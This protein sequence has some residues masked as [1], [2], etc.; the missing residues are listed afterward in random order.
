MSSVTD[1]IRSVRLSVRPSVTFRYRNHIGW[2]TSKII[3]PLNSS[4]WAIWRNENTPKLWR[5][6]GWGQEHK[7]R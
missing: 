6:R 7:K 4:R 3:S 2:N 5:N 1:D